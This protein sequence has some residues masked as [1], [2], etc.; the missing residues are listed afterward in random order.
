MNQVQYAPAATAGGTQD[1]PVSF[2][3]PTLIPSLSRGS[4]YG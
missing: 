3:T 4:P 2:I 1:G